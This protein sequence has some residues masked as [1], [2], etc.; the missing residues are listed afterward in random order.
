MQTLRTDVLIVGAGPVGL[1]GVF[2]CG[3]LDLACIVVDTL[4]QQGGQCISLYPDKPI[5]DIPG[6]RSIAAGELID[7]LLAQ[8]APYRPRYLLG[9]CVVSISAVV[10]FP[11]QRHRFECCPSI[12]MFLH[13]FRNHQRVLQLEWIEIIY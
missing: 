9:D 2:T 3:Q 8:A 6:R 10:G 11:H 5:Y 7:E 4:E 13:L 1:F 12:E